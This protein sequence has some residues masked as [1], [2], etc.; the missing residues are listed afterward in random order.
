MHVGVGRT[1]WLQGC[2]DAVTATQLYPLA[3]QVLW[4]HR[5]SSTH[6]KPAPEAVWRPVIVGRSRA[7]TLECPVAAQWLL[8]RLLAQLTYSRKALRWPGLPWLLIS[9]VAHSTLK[10]SLKFQSVCDLH[11]QQDSHTY[12]LHSPTLRLSEISVLAG[13][14][15]YW[16]SI[17]LSP[18]TINIIYFKKHQRKQARFT[19][20]NIPPQGEYHGHPSG[21]CYLSSEPQRHV[22]CLQSSSQPHPQLS[23]ALWFGL[24]WLPGCRW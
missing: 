5:K 24:P 16:C 18:S 22:W 23:S 14:Y 11:F 3:H 9:S 10:T 2:T 15:I 1:R 6:W 4:Q 17:F 20:T 19:N 8:R 12:I 21:L 13:P 7:A